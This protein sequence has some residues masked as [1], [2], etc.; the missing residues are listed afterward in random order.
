M[1]DDGSAM[2][3]N[4]N[5]LDGDCYNCGFPNFSGTLSISIS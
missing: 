5:F 1:M 2:I 3:T 4:A